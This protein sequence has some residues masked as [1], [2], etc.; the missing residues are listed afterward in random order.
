MDGSP[1]E[2]GTLGIP[3]RPRNKSSGETG[4]RKS[5]LKRTGTL[6]KIKR[7]NPNRGKEASRWLDLGNDPGR[8]C[9]GNWH[10]CETVK[11]KYLSKVFDFS[12][13]IIL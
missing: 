6:M 3:K 9:T 13:R 11:G 7:G 5:P 10:A 1:A 2:H 12:G 4:A 8:D